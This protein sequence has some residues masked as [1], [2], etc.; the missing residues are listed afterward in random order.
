MDL[1]DD[2]AVTTQDLMILCGCLSGD[3]SL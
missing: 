3:L 2:S 1:D